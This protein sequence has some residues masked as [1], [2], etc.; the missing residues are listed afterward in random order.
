MAY[1]AIS[2]GCGVQSTAMAVMSALGDMEPVDVVITADPGWERKATYEARDF[3]A[4]WLRERGMNVEIVHTSFIR[5]E[6]IKPN[7]IDFPFYTENGAPLRRQ[8]TGNFKIDVIKRRIRVING[9]DA[10]DPPH[11]K[12]GAFEMQ[13][14]ISLDEFTRM[15]QSTV[16]FIVNRYPLIEKRIT[17][18]ECIDYLEAHDLPVPVKSSCIGCP[19][20]A[21]SEWIEMRDQTPDEFEDAVAFDETIRNLQSLQR[22]KGDAVYVYKKAEPLSTADLE[23]DAEHERQGKQLPLMICESGYCMV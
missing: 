13:L 9:F 7:H 14:G 22:H 20:R 1:K 8:C 18:N 11:P 15:S 21:A 17:R 12:P 19:Y 3:Y 6:A 16:K 23:H 10:S 2:W 5:D 4:G